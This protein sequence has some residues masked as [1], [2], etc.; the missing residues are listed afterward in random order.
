MEGTVTLTLREYVELMTIQADYKRLQERFNK[1][2][3]LLPVDLD[4][5][6]DEPMIKIGDWND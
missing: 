1:L 2:A 3:D 5:L 4:E 6:F